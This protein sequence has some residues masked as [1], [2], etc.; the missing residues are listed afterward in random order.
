MSDVSEETK[1]EVM[2]LAV[3]L[4][5]TYVEHRNPVLDNR[6]RHWLG[7]KERKTPPRLPDIIE[8]IY[9]QLLDVMG[10]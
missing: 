6:G 3:Q 10:K 4:T 9:R 8:G 5:T 1:R 7:I 2:K